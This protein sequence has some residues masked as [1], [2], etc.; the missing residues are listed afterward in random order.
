MRCPPS[1]RPGILLRS[2][3]A[4]DISTIHTLESAK[5]WTSSCIFNLTL[6]YFKQ[7][8]EIFKDLQNIVRKSP[9]LN[10]LL[11]LQT[12]EPLGLFNDTPIPNLL[13]IESN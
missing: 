6:D 4:N 8:R 11:K 9:L 7:S 10:L 3:L 5:V 13:N 1:T 2:T 12:C